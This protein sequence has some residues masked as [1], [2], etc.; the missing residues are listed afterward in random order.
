MPYWEGFRPGRERARQVRRSSIFRSIESQA[1][2]V[3]GGGALSG[4][5][6]LRGF[7]RL[8]GVP[9]VCV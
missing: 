8:A 9:C 4:A 2:L 3:D 7:G 6:G 1:E 5:R